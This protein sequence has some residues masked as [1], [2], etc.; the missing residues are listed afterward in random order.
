MQPRLHLYHLDDAPDLRSCNL[1]IASVP[2]N[3]RE[4]TS[5][6][7][8]EPERLENF[9]GK[10]LAPRVRYVKELKRLDYGKAHEDEYRFEPWGV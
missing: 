5:K 9:Y 10:S 4:F 8:V 1:V 7:I 3:A 6:P 2:G